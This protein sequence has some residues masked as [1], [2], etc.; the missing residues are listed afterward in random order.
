MIR[1][2]AK[3]MDVGVSSDIFNGID[4]QESSS[5]E[6]EEHAPDGNFWTLSNS[7]L[8]STQMRGSKSFRRGR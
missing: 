4:Y 2:Q 6:D 1:F 7:P 3:G 5:S 8:S